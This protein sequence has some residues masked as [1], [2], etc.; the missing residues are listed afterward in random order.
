MT[1]KPVRIAVQG[2]PGAKRNEVVRF[3]EGVW[4]IKIAA[5]PMEGKANKELIEFLSELLDI[6]K[7]RIGID[8]GATGRRKL[9]ELEGITQEATEER[10]RKAITG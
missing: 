2:H 5:P 7:S 3:E 4:H 6:S 1:E 10:L 8:K 9:I